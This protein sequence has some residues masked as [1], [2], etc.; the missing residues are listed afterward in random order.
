MD[1]NLSIHPR[2][3]PSNIRP[4]QDKSKDC[5]KPHKGHG[6]LAKKMVRLLRRRNA[7]SATLRSISPSMQAAYKTPGSMNQHK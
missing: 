6:K 1:Q 7:H 4:G 5:T 3:W 2:S